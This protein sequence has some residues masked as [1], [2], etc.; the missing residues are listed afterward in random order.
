MTPDLQFDHI[1]LVVKSIATGRAVLG[2]IFR[3]EMWTEEFRDPLNGV[4][5]QFGR[6]P[7]G[8]C[9]ELLEPLDS[10]SPVHAALD[11]GKAILN[12][13]AYR[14]ADLAAQD[15]PMRRAGCARTSEPKP[16]VAYGG[17]RIQFFV[18]PL[19]FIVELIEAPDHEHRFLFDP[20]A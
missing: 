5:V 10:A 17:R 6:D 12:H 16:A 4:L 11:G 8:V 9:Y 20:P 18:T 1:G 7:A 3:I 19:R 13:V 15:E 2:Q 14:V